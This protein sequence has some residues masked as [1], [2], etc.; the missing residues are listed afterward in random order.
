MASEAALWFGGIYKIEL[1]G[2]GYDG[3][4]V[5]M[6]QGNM[7][8]KNKLQLIVPQQALAEAGLD[9]SSL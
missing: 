7:G 9:W 2:R 5:Y 6:W 8:N 1:L 3:R 4:R